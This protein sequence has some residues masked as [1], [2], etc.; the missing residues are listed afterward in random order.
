MV[1]TESEPT[2]SLI[3]TGVAVDS[4]STLNLVY[5]D[6]NAA[7]NQIITLDETVSEDTTIGLAT[8][9]F[10]EIENYER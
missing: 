6:I 8:N 9:N 1:I 10:V 3:T 2:T 7:Q 4:W 5:E